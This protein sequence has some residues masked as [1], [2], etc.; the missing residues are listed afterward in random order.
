MGNS[1]SSSSCSSGA[2]K[3]PEIG[4]GSKRARTNGDDTIP[5]QEQQIAVLNALQIL[6]N[7]DVVHCMKAEHDRYCSRLFL[8]H[9]GGITRQEAEK[10]VG[11]SK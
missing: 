3:S 4:V 2:I 1:N 9:F 7:L 6:D 11:V 8:K 10:K 5:T